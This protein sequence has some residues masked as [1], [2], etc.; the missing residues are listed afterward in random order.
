V[1]GF[2]DENVVLLEEFLLEIVGEGLMEAVMTLDTLAVMEGLTLSVLLSPTV[3][4]L[5]DRFVAVLVG[6]LVNQDYK[7]MPLSTRTAIRE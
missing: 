2:D 6:I 5:P 3:V 7:S 4:A 1:R